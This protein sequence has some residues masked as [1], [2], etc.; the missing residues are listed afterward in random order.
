MPRLRQVNPARIKRCRL[1]MLALTQLELAVRLDTHSTRVSRWERGQ[2]EPQMRFV[3][4]M[5]ELAGIEPAWFFERD[6]E[7]AAA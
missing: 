7:K 2:S 1:E 5:A 4:R 3:R 6:D